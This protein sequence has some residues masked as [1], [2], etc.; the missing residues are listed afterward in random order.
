M[1]VCV[2]SHSVVS[3]CLQLHG[4]WPIRLLCP[5]DFSVRNTGMGCH[6]FLQGIFLTQGSSPHLLNLLHWQVYSLP[7]HHLGSPYT[8]CVCVCAR[9]CVCVCVCACV[10]VCACVCVCVRVCG[11]PRWLRQ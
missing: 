2:L 9:V 10:R 5:E 6:F 4:L 7:L 1:F 8:V 11:L 3:D